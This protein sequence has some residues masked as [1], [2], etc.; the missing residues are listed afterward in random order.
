MGLVNYILT[1]NRMAEFLKALR[2]QAMK[3]NFDLGME[4]G[5]LLY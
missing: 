5:L 3:N 2:D 4:E 1:A